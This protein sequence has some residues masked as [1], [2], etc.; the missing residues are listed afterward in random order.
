VIRFGDI[1]VEHGERGHDIDAANPHA[2]LCGYPDYFRCPRWLDGDGIA[3]V[4]FER[5]SS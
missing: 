3:G 2:C 5:V 1:V 4:T